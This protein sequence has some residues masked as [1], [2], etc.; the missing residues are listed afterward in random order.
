MEDEI[1]Q[2][3]SAAGLITILTRIMRND[4]ERNARNSI[5]NTIFLFDNLPTDKLHILSLL[6]NNIMCLYYIAGHRQLVDVR[7][8]SCN[9]FKMLTII[10][11]LLISFCLVYVIQRE[12]NRIIGRLCN[13]RL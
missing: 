7:H 9:G 13:N 8:N 12:I 1:S 4:E 10:V 6:L 2:M 3:N 5:S 11:S